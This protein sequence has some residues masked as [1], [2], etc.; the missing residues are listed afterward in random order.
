MG[1]GMNIVPAKK[2]AVTCIFCGTLRFK[3]QK[4]DCICYEDKE[5]NENFNEQQVLHT[6]PVGNGIQRRNRN[7]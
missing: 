2:K 6:G 3:A 4:H 5:V 7:E 1:Q